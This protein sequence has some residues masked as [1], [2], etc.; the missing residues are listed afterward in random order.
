[1]ISVV[2]NTVISIAFAWLTFGGLSLIS[3]RAIVI[4]SIPQSFMITLMSVAVPGLLTARRLV[5][6]QIDPI[7]AEPSRWSLGV[8]AL[9][10]ALVAVVAGLALHASISALAM[11][12]VSFPTL[13]F[14]KIAYGAALAAVVTP[15]MLRYSLRSA[16]RR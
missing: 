5:A 9:S 10:A 15:L 2:I 1:M 8:R 14:V 12:E 16:A 3:T 11:G 13:L 7:A 6:G 4:D